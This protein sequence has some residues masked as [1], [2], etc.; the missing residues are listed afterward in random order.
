M[1]N[2]IFNVY[3]WFSMVIFT[4]MFF[5]FANEKDKETG[6]NWPMSVVIRMSLIAGFLGWP[7]ALYR[8]F[9]GKHK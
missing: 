1:I 5:V 8:I 9:T 6:E 3:F 7:I 4:W 2:F